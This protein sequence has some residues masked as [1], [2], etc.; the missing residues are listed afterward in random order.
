MLGLKE[1]SICTHTHTH[2]QTSTFILF[3]Y[4]PVEACFAPQSKKWIDNYLMSLKQ[5]IC[6]RVG[7]RLNVQ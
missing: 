1:T 3:S 2:T 4:T 6:Y 7:L 5:W